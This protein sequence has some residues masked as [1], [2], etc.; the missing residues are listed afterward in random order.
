MGNRS[1]AAVQ[2]AA[3]E[4]EATNHGR[5]LPMDDA[6]P[7]SGESSGWLH[8][9]ARGWLAWAEERQDG[10]R[11]DTRTLFIHMVLYYLRFKVASI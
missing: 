10:G 8:C 3:A 1:S 2:R 11:H 4:P 5:T 9:C 6:K 7:E